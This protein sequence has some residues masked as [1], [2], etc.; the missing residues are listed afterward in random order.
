MKASELR[1]KSVEE[2]Q[3]EQI[4]LLEQQFKLRMK[5]ASGQ[6]S[7]THELGTVRRNIARVKTILR[8][9]QGN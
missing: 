1:E 6:L 5:S 2:L 8:Q 4:N 7:K 9:K 3:Q